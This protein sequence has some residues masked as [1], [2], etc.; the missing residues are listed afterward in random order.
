MLINSIKLKNIR[1][2]LDEKIEFPEGSVLLSG[3]IGS[4]KSTILLALEFALFGI[5][6]G[7]LSGESLLRNGKNEG[8]VEIDIN[9]GDKNYIVKRTLKRASNNK[10]SQTA[11]SVIVDGFQKLGMA[12][13]LK[14]FILKALNY[15][16]EMLKKKSLIYRYTVYTPQED[17]KKILLDDKEARLDT[18]RKVFGIDKYKKIRENTA[19][20]LK[21]LRE[22]RRLYEGQA[23]GLEEKQLNLDTKNQEQKV[24]AEAKQALAPQLEEAKKKFDLQKVRLEKVEKQIEEQ[25]QLKK[26]LEINRK[27]LDDKMEQKLRSKRQIE[28]IEKDL[29]QQQESLSNLKLEKPDIDLED[30]NKKLSDVENK[31]LEITKKI[32]EIEV[33]KSYLEQEN[34]KILE[35]NECPTC[36]QSVPDT[37][38]KEIELT[39]NAKISEI[40]RAY[41]ELHVDQART[42]KEK[43]ELKKQLDIIKE[44]DQQYR[45]LLQRKAHI[46][47]LVT[48]KQNQMQNYIDL[49]MKLKKEIGAL[50][51][52]NA[53][54]N[55]K[56]ESFEKVDLQRQ[57]QLLEE[58]RDRFHKFEIE[59]AKLDKD[60]VNIAASIEV[61]KKEIAEKE[62]SREK[63]KNVNQYY[64]WLDKF[65]VNLMTTM[66][67]HVMAQVYNEFNSLFQDWFSIL[68][69]DENVSIRL[70]DEFSPVIEQNGYEIDLENMSGGEK[71]AVALAYRLALNKVINNI[72]TDI[73]TRDLLILDEPTD[74]FSSEQL[75]KVRD[76][77]EQLGLK[78]VIIVSH[79]NK[80]ESFVDKIIRISKNEHISKLT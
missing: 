79:E 16:P 42:S 27:A 3:D 10:V 39:N 80:I 5:G 28:D 52:E 59:K 43:D 24:L 68:I 15:P 58:T 48:D 11:G 31:F 65:F 64:D 76:V 63:I 8:E 49:D 56:L 2:Y 61:L 4:G 78:Q 34:Q 32:K 51:V 66:E 6:K 54:L 40:A 62:K 1:S 60:I 20:Y 25:N 41:D 75:D 47:H 23:Q 70:D 67:K 77:L 38:K 33:K 7:M 21:N 9:I 50:N 26:Q 71:T 14:S 37:H 12:S 53:E 55:K 17:M 44:Q 46:E 36:K 30:F 22:K 29:Q 57:K 18:L 35:L 72:I 13:E 74:G 45:L 69:E 19:I 73:N